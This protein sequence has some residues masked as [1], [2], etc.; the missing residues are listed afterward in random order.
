M[1]E[2]YTQPETP[3]WESPFSGTTPSDYYG[4]GELRR[5]TEGINGLEAATIIYDND[6]V[7]K[8]RLLN[9]E[10]THEAFQTFAEIVQNGEVINIPLVQ[11][12]GHNTDRAMSQSAVT[13]VADQLQEQ[14]N[15]CV[16]GM[17]R[18]PEENVTLE[19]KDPEHREHCDIAE[20]AATDLYGHS[21]TK[22]YYDI[23]DL[24]LLVSAMKYNL[25][26]INS[27]LSHLG[28]QPPTPEETE[29]N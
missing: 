3:E 12:I 9:L 5:I 6:T 8:Q 15:D 20:K 17:V 2:Q 11:Q 29:G 27:Y 4:D 18:V 10:K 22:M 21:L 28:Y 1:D 24:K 7:L 14:I 13:E 26:S 23:E 25:D 16:F 19:V